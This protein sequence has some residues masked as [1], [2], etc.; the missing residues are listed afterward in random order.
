MSYIYKTKLFKNFIICIVHQ[1]ATLCLSVVF[2]RILKKKG[3]L[4]NAS[5]CS[6]QI[7]PK[8]DEICSGETQLTLIRFAD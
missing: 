8:Q 7:L 5:R 6:F 4:I 2:F 1:E 3:I